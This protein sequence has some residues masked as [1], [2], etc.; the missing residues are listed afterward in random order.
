LKE[1][2]DATV[3]KELSAQEQTGVLELALRQVREELC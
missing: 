1:A 3:V 2:H